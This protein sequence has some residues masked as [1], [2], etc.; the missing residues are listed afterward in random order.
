MADNVLTRK[1]G[2]LKVWQWGAIGGGLGLGFLL[3]HKK[4]AEPTEAEEDA[5]LGGAGRGGGVGSGGG[6]SVESVPATPSAPGTVGEVGAPGPAGEAGIAGPAGE[7][8]SAELNSQV[9]SLAS[10]VLS[11]E[12]HGAPQTPGPGW[13]QNKEPGN[14]RQ[15]Q[16]YKIVKGKNGKEEHVYKSGAKIVTKKASSTAKKVASRVK[17]AAKKG[18]TPAKA[19]GNQNKHTATIHHS[20]PAT[21]LKNRVKATTPVHKTASAKITPTH[22]SKPA[23]HTVAKKPAKKPAAKKKKK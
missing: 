3:L 15:G 11:I 7:N 20:K 19:R 4:A 23:S 10:K 17:D 21:P 8:P 14:P 13:L 2:P 22:S 16:Y 6:G 1:A 18:V 9:A 5:L 12:H